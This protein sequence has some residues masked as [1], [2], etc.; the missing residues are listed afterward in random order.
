M[1]GRIEC[2]R[3]ELARKYPYKYK[4]TQNPLALFQISDCIHSEKD[5]ENYNVMIEPYLENE[6]H[7]MVLRDMVKFVNESVV[8]LRFELSNIGAI[9]SVFL[10][11]RLKFSDTAT[12]LK[13]DESRIRAK[14]R[15]TE[16][17]ILKSALIPTFDLNLYAPFGAYYPPSTKPDMI[18]LWDIEKAIDISNEFFS[19]SKPIVQNMPPIDFAENEYYVFLGL[20]QEF[21]IDWEIIDSKLPDTIKGKLVVRIK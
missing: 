4:D 21:E 12:I 3:A 13:Y 6:P 19:E 7:N 14:L 9:P 5:Y 1:E 20:E 18:E 8:P 2:Y 16:E 11:I 10:G 17:P 15:N